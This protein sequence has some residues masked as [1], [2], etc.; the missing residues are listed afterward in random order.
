M[1]K[2][3][4]HAKALVAALVAATAVLLLTLD[5]A[6]ADTVLDYD[7]NRTTNPVADNITRLHVNKLEKGARD[8]VVGA[9]LCII[10]KETG[11][12]VTEWVS[13][14]SVHEIARNIGDKSSLDID[15]VYIL[16]ELSAPEGYAKAQDTEFII[17]S[18]NFN[19][20]GEILS[21]EDAEFD[22]ISGHGDVQA[23]VINLYDEATLT[24]EEVQTV[25]RERD[26]EQGTEEERQNQTTTGDK[27]STTD[28]SSNQDSGS[29]SDNGSSSG[30]T[31]DNT[32]GS[33][34]SGNN[35]NNT[36]SSSGST[37]QAGG[38]QTQT[39]PKM[40]DDTPYSAIYVMGIFGAVLLVAGYQLRRRREA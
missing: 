8:Y 6:F 28:N 26:N 7:A 35:N 3:A 17:H 34:N 33:G 36:S 31:S 21:G 14:G 15:K 37:Q 5:I 29:K 10:E 12:V 40:S 2:S 23:F 9:R 18:E 38:Q 4:R 25:T 32:S 19:T 30:G 20:T 16:R 11:R 22:T 1:S 13:D 24:T 39:L 27:T